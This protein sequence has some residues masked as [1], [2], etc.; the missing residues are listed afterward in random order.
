MLFPMFVLQLFNF[1]S[2]KMAL[3]IKKRHFGTKTFDFFNYPKSG[4]LSVT[5]FLKFYIIYAVSCNI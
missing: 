5:L 3:K 4:H 2:A 1:Q